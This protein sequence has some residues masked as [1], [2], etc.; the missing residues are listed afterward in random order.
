MPRKQLLCLPPSSFH[1]PP[2]APSECLFSRLRLARQPLPRHCSKWWNFKQH[3]KV[4]RVKE[5]QALRGGYF[6]PHSQ[7]VGQHVGGPALPGIL[8]PGSA[9]P[10]S[11]QVSQLLPFPIFWAHIV[12][13]EFFPPDFQGLMLGRPSSPMGRWEPAQTN[14][15]TP[16]RWGGCVHQRLPVLRKECFLFSVTPAECLR[17]F[18]HPEG[19]R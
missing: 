12:P 3:N 1:S 10:G 6:G 7:S 17:C 4:Q 13:T 18:I 9:P 19:N 16:K 15:L 11:S 5:M 8:T 14:I 2:Q